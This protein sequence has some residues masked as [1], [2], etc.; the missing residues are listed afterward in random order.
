MLSFEE[1]YRN[2]YNSVL[3]KQEDK[4]YNG[5]KSVIQE[6]LENISNFDMQLAYKK[7][8]TLNQINITSIEAIEIGTYYLQTLKNI[9]DEYI[10]CTNM[11]SHIMKY[12]VNKHL[13]YM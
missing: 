4:L 7:V 12:M 13:I 3:H 6:H 1:L 2:V 11:I 10:L 9:W 5:I 8:E